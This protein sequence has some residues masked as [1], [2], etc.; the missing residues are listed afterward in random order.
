MPSPMKATVRGQVR[1][2]WGGRGASG[3]DSDTG[4]LLFCWTSWEMAAALDAWGVP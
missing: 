3:E 2:G 1:G 4:I